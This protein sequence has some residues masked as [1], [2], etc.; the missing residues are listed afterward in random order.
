MD[1][2]FGKC[3]I[4]ITFLHS[5]TR[6]VASTIASKKSIFLSIGFSIVIDI[7]SIQHIRYS[8]DQLHRLHESRISFGIVIRFF[9]S[10]VTMCVPWND[11]MVSDVSFASIDIPLIYNY[12]L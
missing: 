2:L 4:S 8:I 12:F 3:N 6:P 5:K 7:L 9:Q 11:V 1:S 10:I